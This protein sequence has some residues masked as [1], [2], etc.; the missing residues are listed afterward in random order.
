MKNKSTNLPQ[1][2]HR[3]I[4]RFER[5]RFSEGIEGD[6]SEIHQERI[7]KH[8]KK[9]AQLLLFIDAIGFWRNN[10]F[11]KESKTSNTINMISS[12]FKIGIRNIYKRSLISGINIFGFGFAMSI[13]FLIISI[14]TDLKS[15]DRFHPDA[16]R[17]YRLISDQ[18]WDGESFGSAAVAPLPLKNYLLEYPEIEE[19]C[20]IRRRLDQDLKHGEE[21]TSMRGLFAD[22]NFFDFFGFKL[23]SGNKNTCLAEPYSIVLS[24]ATSKKLFGEEDPMG[25]IVSIEGLELQVKGVSSTSNLKTH[26]PFDALVS[27]SSLEPLAEAGFYKPELDNW[28]AI[29]NGL[30]YVKLRSSPNA[31]LENQINDIAKSKYDDTRFEG[32]SFRFQSI[33]SIYLGESLQNQ[34]ATTVPGKIIMFLGVIALLI[35]GL[36]IF[37]YTNLT[38]AQTLSRLKEI[39]VRKSIGASRGNIF[40]QI[41]SEAIIISLVAMIIAFMLLQL[42][43]PFFHQLMALRFL[44]IEPNFGPVTYFLFL[45]FALAT[46]L[47]AGFFPAIYISKLS[48]VLSLK[49]SISNSHTRFDWKKIL[50][51]MQFIIGTI[52]LISTI[53]TQKQVNL[54]L[55]S[56]YGFNREQIV[57]VRLKGVSHESF[58][59]AIRSHENIIS[60]SSSGGVPGLNDFDR[61]GVTP[62]G[63]EKP[64]VINYLTIDENFIDHLGL[65]IIAGKN[66]DG[67]GEQPENKVI[68]NR[69]AVEQYGWGS[70][71]DALG[72]V[73]DPGDAPLLEVVGVVEDFN[74]RSKFFPIDPLALLYN[75][76][77][78]YLS[79]VKIKAGKQEEAI[80]FL[81]K[82]W[83]QFDPNHVFDFRFYEEQIR[84]SYFDFIDMSNI[85]SFFSLVTILIGCLGLL[86]MT[87]FWTGSRLKEIGIRKVMGAHS[88]GLYLLLNRQL[89]ALVIISFLIASPLAYWLNNLWMNTFAYKISFGFETLYLAFLILLF[90]ATII[91]LFPSL[92]ASRLNPVE[93]I[94]DE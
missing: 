36:A 12:N 4:N 58:N 41:I 40:W 25:K 85:I 54:F 93:I 63:S 65:K 8:G 29:D 9:A 33:T 22:A 23:I 83:R 81:E 78:F 38:I 14:I 27:I 92:K 13:C 32:T 1:W 79:S 20:L 50:I 69:K 15:Y 51:G 11:K 19:V 73:L 46:G 5:N 53:L 6:L 74:Q 7:N 17:I 68:I 35:T 3:F 75:P 89:L 45:I 43:L 56:D 59:N 37:N 44:Q 91:T 80:S 88:T 71:H 2:F 16:N 42:I 18:Y 55:E 90:A 84:F 72:K 26:M 94:K 48:P 60:V 82:T 67:P 62:E 21:V 86:A 52:F 77:Q 49:N 34:I 66:F 64:T 57:N 47:I 70:P 24:E 31:Y 87:I 76:D 28:N 39:G 10:A 30:V 61:L